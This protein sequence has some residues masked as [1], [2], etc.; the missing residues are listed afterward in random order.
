VQELD[1]EDLVMWNRDVLSS[2]PN[3]RALRVGSVDD[4][5]LAVIVASVPRLAEL[6]IFEGR[7]LTDAAFT[8]LACLE[9]L[10]VLS[11]EDCRQITDYR[12]QYLTCLERLET[13]RLK[14]SRVSKAAASRLW[15]QLPNLQELV[16]D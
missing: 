14:S 3:L 11:V 9:L 16:V 6:S 8:S 2:F 1:L 12:L 7:Y 5:D 10:R 13:V 15:D 4:Q